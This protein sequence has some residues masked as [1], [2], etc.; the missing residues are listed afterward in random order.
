MGS[1]P[2]SGP[3]AI[4]RTRRRALRSAAVGRAPPCDWPEPI[5]IPS[6]SAAQQSAP[7][8]L[9]RRRSGSCRRN[10]H[11]WRGTS[12]TAMATA[13]DPRERRSASGDSGRR[14]SGCRPRAART[15]ADSRTGTSCG[16]DAC[17][18]PRRRRRSCRERAARRSCPT[19]DGARR[20]HR[21]D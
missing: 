4:P 12:G 15:T 21:P 10:G 6:C 14:T 3:P 9:R 1:A 17:S 7:C 13:C 5:A 8:F 20:G 18:P 16:P 2:P 11:S 19:I